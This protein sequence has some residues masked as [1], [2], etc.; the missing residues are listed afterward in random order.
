[1]SIHWLTILSHDS[2]CHPQWNLVF[3][4]RKYTIRSQNSGITSCPTIHT[5]LHANHCNQL[6]KGFNA[7]VGTVSIVIA[8]FRVQFGKKT[9][10]SE[11][12]KDL[13]IARVQI[14]WEKKS[15]KARDIMLLLINKIMI[16][17]CRTESHA[18]VTCKIVYSLNSQ[19]T[20][21]CQNDRSQNVLHSLS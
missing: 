14:D 20:I 11:F 5:H 15:K 18:C 8:W 13:K 6:N 7:S 1:M 16:K 2:L 19:Q 10:T 9:C 12:F 3:L 21:I 17:L 4:L